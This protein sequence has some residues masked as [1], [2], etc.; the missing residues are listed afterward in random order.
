LSGVIK[1]NLPEDA[2]L[3]ENLPQRLLELIHEQIR[4][5]ADLMRDYAKV[6][7]PVDTGSLRDSIR[8]EEVPTQNEDYSREVR[9]RAG[10]YT[11]NPKTGRI[12]D[13]AVFVEAKEHFMELAWNMVSDQLTTILEVQIPNMVKGSE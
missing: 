8:I 4:Q 9:V 7:C 6:F 1:L 11:T 2:Q 12:V 3:L 5:Q 10:G 13:Y